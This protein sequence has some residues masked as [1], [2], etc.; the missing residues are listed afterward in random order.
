MALSAIHASP[1]CISPSAVGVSRTLS[2]GRIMLLQGPLTGSRTGIQYGPLEVCQQIRCKNSTFLH[3]LA[4]SLPTIL[5]INTRQG[6]PTR[7][8]IHSLPL[9]MPYKSLLSQSCF[10]KSGMK[11]SNFICISSLGGRLSPSSPKRQNSHHREGQHGN[12]RT[13]ALFM[14]AYLFENSK[15]VNN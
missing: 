5:D 3:L 4:L 13:S 8:V 1:S 10:R 7:V 11:S 15:Y 2:Q 12:C 9:Y 14:V 6:E